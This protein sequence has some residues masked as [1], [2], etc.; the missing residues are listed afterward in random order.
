MQ[1]KLQVCSGSNIGSLHSLHSF[2]VKW[3]K[4]TCPL[5]TEIQFRVS[6]LPDLHSYCSA[7][8]RETDLFNHEY[9]YRLNWKTRSS[10]TS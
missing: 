2:E 8:R 6:V 9:D 5:R 3:K 10:V 4:N 7:R 1:Y